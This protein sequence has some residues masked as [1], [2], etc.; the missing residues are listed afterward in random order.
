MDKNTV[1]GIVVIGL[2]I[3]GWVWLGGRQEKKN[4]EIAREQFVQDSIANPWKY[5]GTPDRS[6]AEQAEAQAE[7]MERLKTEEEANRTSQIANMGQAL[8]DA[9]EGE[10]KIYVMEN[11]VMKV[12]ISSKGGKVDNVELK[13]YTRYQKDEEGNRLPL[14]LFDRNSSAFDVTFFMRKSYNYAQINTG[15]Y[16]FVSD[17]PQFITVD[18]HNQTLAMRL[19]I[20]DEAEAYVEY[21][22][23][24]RPGEYMIDFDVRFVGLREWTS[25][26]TDFSIDWK[27][28]TLQ[29]EKGY[30]NENNYTDLVYKFPGAN[31]I[32]KLGPSES[33]KNGRQSTKVEWLSFK[34]QY[35]SSAFI[36]D[37][38]FSE[39]S[40][41]YD[42]Y[43]EN[44]GKIKDFSASFMVPY[45][46]NQDQY[47]FHFYFGPNHYRT[48]KQYDLKLEKVI[49]LGGNAISWIN[50][51]FYIPVMNWLSRFIS[52][53]GIIILLLTLMVKIIIL[54]LTYKSYMSSAKMKA[55][56]P[57]VDEINARYTGQSQEEM[58]K[59]Q[60][61]TMALYKQYGVSQLGGCLPMLIQMPII[62]ALFRFFPASIELR[63]QPFL[64]A[65]D[66]SAY[67][68]ILDLPFKIPFYGDHVSLFAL[69][70]AVTTYLYSR[71]NYKQGA[72]QGQ[73]Q[74]AGM[75]FMMLYLMPIMMLCLLNSYSSGLSY[76]YTVSQLATMGIMWG[77]RVFTNEDK[78]R[79][80]MEAKAR[81]KASDPEKAKK[82][83][84]F[85]QRY[86]EALRQ[87]QQA[88]RQQQQKQQ[89][90]S[91]KTHTAKPRSTNMQPAK[92]RKK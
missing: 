1:I 23:T 29:N 20:D 13:E 58:M 25:T 73:Q 87:Q 82:K 7:Y 56:K 43:K 64:W 35:F 37:D 47:K 89:G 88:Q 32:E 12:Y 8:V 67:D 31:K 75:K 22:Y 60:Q 77:F 9:R 57:E 26:L 80:K 45:Y 27:A 71:Y 14:M 3:F 91:A 76:Y 18:D 15:E 48:L 10:E 83:S 85:Q 24:V 72:V 5:N 2:L 33:S 41:R 70:M 6:A 54:P 19:P 40:Y 92:K 68:S 66:L 4:Q 38:S 39:A 30:K 61:A 69:L 11:D 36:A 51:G 50:T 42:S 78:L 16:S 86:E 17:Q 55:L 74:M 44:T 53:Y 59:K 65:D 62:F 63:G 84:G 52:S 34:Q 28:T 49:P 90:G 21:I 79:A 81:Q 46:P